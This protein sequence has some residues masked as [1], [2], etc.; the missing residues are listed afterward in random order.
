MPKLNKVQWFHFRWTPGAGGGAINVNNFCFDP[1]GDHNYTYAANQTGKTSLILMMMSEYMKQNIQM[2]DQKRQLDS[3]IENTRADAPA[4]I[5]AEWISDL[6]P[7]HRFL[8]L[9]WIYLI[10]NQR[11]SNLKFSDRAEKYGAILSYEKGTLTN[12]VSDLGLLNGDDLD[13]ALPKSCSD[14]R[15]ALSNLPAGV[16]KVTGMVK[17]DNASPKGNNILSKRK[18]CI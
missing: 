9:N 14:A 15:V 11:G 1:H 16:T 2:G 12:P 6:N 7:E 3:Y 17:L 18:Q 4:L 10:S 8:V 13:Q 5:A